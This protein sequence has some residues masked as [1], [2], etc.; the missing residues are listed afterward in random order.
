M[1]TRLSH[2]SSALLTTLPSFVCRL[3]LSRLLFI[4]TNISLSHRY[5]KPRKHECPPTTLP[6]SKHSTLNRACHHW[7][8]GSFCFILVSTGSFQTPPSLQMQDGAIPTTTALCFP[9]FKCEMEGSLPTPT[10]TTARS[11][12]PNAPSLL[13]QQRQPSPLLTTQR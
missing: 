8:V 13:P 11:L 12:A 9:R 5:T 2:S 1:N 4:L 3:V 6:D 10:T 7:Y